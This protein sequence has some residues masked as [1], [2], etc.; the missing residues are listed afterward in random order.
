MDF[1]DISMRQVATRLRNRGYVGNSPRCGLRL[2]GDDHDDDGRSRDFWLYVDKQKSA[3]SEDYSLT[4]GWQGRTFSH[5][6]PIPAGSLSV[7]A[8]NYCRNNFGRPVSLDGWFCAAIYTP[9]E[10]ERQTL[11]ELI[12]MMGLSEENEQFQELVKELG[13]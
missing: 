12:R 4:T 8:C 9:K 6:R 7:Y 10:Q 13:F 11:A 3:F 1:R 2:S 5:K